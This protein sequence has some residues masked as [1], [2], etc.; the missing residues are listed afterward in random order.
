M[1]SNT[2]RLPDKN[3][4]ESRVTLA[5]AQ[6]VLVATFVVVSVLVVLVFIWYAADLL[7]MVQRV[8]IQ[9]LKVYCAQDSRATT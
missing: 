9:P 3:L 5:V 6:R 2:H 4:D 1:S 7:T 8:R